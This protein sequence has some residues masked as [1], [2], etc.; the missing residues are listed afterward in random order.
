[1]DKT[2][3][4]YSPYV[5]RAAAILTAAYVAGTD[6]SPSSINLNESI[7]VY[8]KLQLFVDF[9]IGSLT[10]TTLKIEFSDDGTNW[11][12]ETVEAIGTP[13]GGSVI[14]TE[15]LNTRTFI[16]TGKY[17]ISLDINN[18]WIRVSAIGTGTLTGSS[19]AI[20]AILGN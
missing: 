4:Q 17:R 6:I 19:L 10:S 9:T 7:F 1:M 14:T 12:Q 18:K 13:S 5:I 8:D 15:N 16:A 2:L 20:T 11:Y 3:S